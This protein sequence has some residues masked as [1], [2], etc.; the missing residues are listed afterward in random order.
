MGYTRESNGSRRYRLS[1]TCE[2]V[3]TKEGQDY[4]VDRHV[5]SLGALAFVAGRIYRPVEK[6]DHPLKVVNVNGFMA[7]SK[8]YDEVGAAMASE[9]A[10]TAVYDTW[11]VMTKKDIKDPLLVAS[12]GGRRM[13]DVMEELDGEQGETAAVGHSMGGPVAARLA[14]HDPRVGYWVGDASAGIEHERMAQVH[15]ENGKEIL[16]EEALPIGK[17]AAAKVGI[18][19]LALIYGTRMAINPSQP[20]R[21]A[22]LLCT[23]SD[24][25][26]YLQIA[27]D[28]GVM[29]GA[30]LHDEDAFF[31]LHKQLAA[32]NKR[33]DL[34]DI[35]RVSYG[36]KHGHANTH[37]LENAKLRL[38]VIRSLQSKKLAGTALASAA[39]H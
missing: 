15:I 6:P 20:I 12:M 31:H 23:D 24:V 17:Y 13:I 11:H 7:I 18:A 4:T 28:N 25:T 5:S 38:E 33:A 3:A 22:Y 8:I 19:K 21:Q 36:T 10:T 26:P 14:A 16:S 39:N 1:S 27:H 29:N 34:Y 2:V 37:P 32:I 35:T 9:G 30:L